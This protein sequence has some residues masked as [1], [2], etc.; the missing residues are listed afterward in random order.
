MNNFIPTNIVKQRSR[1][2]T[3]FSKSITEN[4]NKSYI[5]KTLEVFILESG[6]PGSVIARTDSYKP[7]VIKQNL[8]IGTIEHVKITEVTEAYLIGI[9]K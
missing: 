4:K 1:T 3:S 9:L 7:V 6:K 8:L 2:I 5:G